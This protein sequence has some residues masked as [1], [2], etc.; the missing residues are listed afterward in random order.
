MPT[1]IALFTGRN[2]IIADVSH[3]TPTLPSLDDVASLLPDDAKPLP[4]HADTIELL[5]LNILSWT[6]TPTLVAVDFRPLFFQMDHDLFSAACKAKQIAF[7][8]KN[9]RFCPECGSP[10]VYHSDISRVCPSCHHETYPPI[11]PAIIVRI[12]RGDDEILLVKAKNFRG[13]HYGLVAGF[14]ET[15]E[16]LEQCVRREVREETGLEISDIQYAGNQPWPFPSG[17]MIGFTAKYASGDISIQASELRD[18][19]FF[20][21]DN[22]PPLPDQMSIARQLIDAWSSC[23]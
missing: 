1:P 7:W 2:K 6:D 23:D 11:S 9:S 14:L 17:V 3:P 22:L 5:T 10:M 19:R 12:E 21:R 15:N 16:T 13:D 20:R 8:D 18:A 4:V